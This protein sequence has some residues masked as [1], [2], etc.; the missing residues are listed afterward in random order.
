MQ[1]KM[2]P[3][4][5][6]LA[7]LGSAAAA[8][9]NGA[10]SEFPAGGIVFKPEKDI[11]IASEDLEIGWDLIRVRYVFMSSAS[12]PLQRT[13]GFPMARV[14]LADGPDNIGNTTRAESGDDPHNYMAF[15]VAV[16]GKPLVPALHEYAWSG[17]TNVTGKLLALGVP[18][19]AGDIGTYGKLAKLPENT[20]GELTRQKLVVKESREDGW[21]IPLWDYQSVYEWTQTF[22]PGK[23]IVEIAYRPLF[24]T[25][26]DSHSYYEDGAGA[27]L[28]CLEGEIRDRL[29]RARREQ[30]S[31]PVPFTVGYILQTATNWHGPIGEFRLTV[32]DG[33]G[34]LFSFCVPEGLKPA[35]DGTSWVAEDFVPSSD[36]DIVFYVQDN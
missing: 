24:G 10:V 27:P 17:D 25:S 23:T 34:S 30:I 13:I 4:L 6:V 26:Y 33:H 8:M 14:S 9:A 19:F 36:L 1:H 29:A 35:G 2:I 22:A 11:S 20:I 21:V 15:E 16:N 5:T 7:I 12:E 31:S 18:L 3:A 28:Y 32:S